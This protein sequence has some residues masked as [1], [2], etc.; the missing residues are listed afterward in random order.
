M[1]RPVRTSKVERGGEPAQVFILPHWRNTDLALAAK[2]TTTQVPIVIVYVP[3]PVATA[4]V[5]SLARPGANVTGL[6]MLA[7]EVSQ[8]A[9]EVLRD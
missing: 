1:Q 9:L 4:L 6:S 5:R 3:D 2:Q 8:K 7:S